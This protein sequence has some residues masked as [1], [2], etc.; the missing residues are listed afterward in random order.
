[1]YNVNSGMVPSYRQDLIPPLVSEISDYPWRNKRL[2]SVP[3][4]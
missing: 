2:I 4:N 3:I 1:M